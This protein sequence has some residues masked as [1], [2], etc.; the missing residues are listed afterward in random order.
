MTGLTL[1]TPLRVSVGAAFSF[2]MQFLLGAFRPAMSRN[3]DIA[4]SSND[5]QTSEL[6]LETSPLTR[7]SRFQ[8]FE[9]DAW[10][11]KQSPDALQYYLVRGIEP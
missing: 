4:A 10:V 3:A 8:G 11:A 1:K 7:M 6:G 2:G 5:E 9:L